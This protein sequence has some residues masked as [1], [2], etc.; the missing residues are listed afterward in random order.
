MRPSPELGMLLIKFRKIGS[1]RELRRF[2]LWFMCGGAFEAR[3]EGAFESLLHRMQRLGFHGL[4]DVS[5]VCRENC[6]L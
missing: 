2:M 6:L 1:E 3:V 5:V 4:C